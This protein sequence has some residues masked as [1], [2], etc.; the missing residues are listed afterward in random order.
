[1]VT[2]D[3]GGAAGEI[4]VSFFGGRSVDGGRTFSSPQHVGGLILRGNRR[5]RFKVL[6]GMRPN[7][8]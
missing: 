1:M 5:K 2:S 6:V 3:S 7:K 8:H 4:E